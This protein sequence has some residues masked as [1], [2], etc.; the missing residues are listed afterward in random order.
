MSGDASGYLLFTRSL[1]HARYHDDFDDE[2]FYRL[3]GS[4]PHSVFKVKADS[5]GYSPIRHDETIR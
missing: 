2:L 5:S 1:H 3:S 4:R